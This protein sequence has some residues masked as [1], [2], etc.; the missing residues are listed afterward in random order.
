MPDPMRENEMLNKMF[1]G[2]PT[3]LDLRAFIQ[4]FDRGGVVLASVLA[5]Q[6]GLKPQKAEKGMQKEWRVVGALAAVD[7]EALSFAVAKQRDLIET[8]AVEYLREFKTGDKLLRTGFGAPPIRL[9]WAL[10]PTTLKN[11]P[12]KGWPYPGEL[13]E[14]PKDLSVS[15]GD[16]RCGFMG[17]QCYSQAGAKGGFRFVQVELK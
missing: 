17:N 10:P 4:P 5:T 7:E 15:N 3:T 2:R 9:G 16:L 12:W 1:G 14:V 13:V 6:D 8:W 11:P